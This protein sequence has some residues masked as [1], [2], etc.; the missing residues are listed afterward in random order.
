[1]LHESVLVGRVVGGGPVVPP[2]VIWMTGCLAG[3]D[4]GKSQWQ[5]GG[6]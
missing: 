5:M 3:K 2:T 1:M 6:I 4:D